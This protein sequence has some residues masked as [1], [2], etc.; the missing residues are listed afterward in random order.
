[1]P[2][3]HPPDSFDVVVIGSGFGGAFAARELVAAGLRV[4]MV[5]RGGWISRGPEN[6]T[7]DGAVLRTPA[8]DP[9]SPYR[10]IQGRR[11][12]QGRLCACVGGPSVFYGGAS[13]RFREADFRAAPEIAGPAGVSWPFGYDTLS[14]Y[15]DEAEAILGIAGEAGAD[16]TEPP[17][18]G[19][20]PL[21]PAPM[22][23]VSR[24]VAAAARGMGLHPFPI[25]LNLGYD[26][27]CRRCATCDGFPCAIGAKGDVATRIVPGLVERG[28]TLLTETAAVRLVLRGERVEAVECRDRRT[29]ETLTLPAGAVVLAAGALATPHLLLASGAER[30]SPAREAV[31]RYLVRH[32]NA[33]EFGFFPTPPDAVG[34]HHKQLAVHDFYFGAPEADAPRGKL[35]SLQQVPTP[36]LALVQGVLPPAVVRVIAPLVR[37]MTG[38]LCIAEDQ[39]RVES[40]VTL[41]GAALDRL[42]LPRMTVTHRYTPRDLAARAALARRA[43]RILRR[44]GAWGTL[45]HPI[46]TFS[47]VAGTVRMGDDPARAPLD[48]DGRFR[49][50][51]NLF[52][53]DASAFSTA[54]GVNP[55][56]TIAANALRVGRG[57]ATRL[58]G[59]QA[60]EAVR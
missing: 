28:M 49:G 40:G 21:P 44:A 48:A 33:I 45:T 35:G 29:G 58:A 42:G 36:A 53:T 46:N 10:V 27:G 26:R 54:A 17:R 56:L 22:A 37:R 8:N 34:E 16:P 50:L 2:R 32:C 12:G 5:E 1:M 59:V 7:P 24:R 30:L 19:P 31:G 14:P 55:S 25:P 60:A 13:F 23:E 57:M 20:Y 38:L 18:S 52:V 39:P 11:P 6:W 41:D 15:Y 47:H 9:D 3:T 51:E 4:A 43:A